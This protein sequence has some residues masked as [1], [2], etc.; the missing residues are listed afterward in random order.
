MLLPKSV[1]TE[2]QKQ[3]IKITFT[4]SAIKEI[5]RAKLN[6]DFGSSSKKLKRLQRQIWHFPKPI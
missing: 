4:V 3:S 1:N 5:D 2:W 6:K